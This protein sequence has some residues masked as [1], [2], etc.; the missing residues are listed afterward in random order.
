MWS[1][2]NIDLISEIKCGDF[3]AIRNLN[4]NN[5]NNNIDNIIDKNFES[6]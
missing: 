2:Y 1:S 6:A 5:S 4:D 3:N